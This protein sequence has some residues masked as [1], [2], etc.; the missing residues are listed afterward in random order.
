MRR[1][2][3]TLFVLSV[4][5]LVSAV[6]TARSEEEQCEKDNQAYLK[7]YSGKYLYTKPD[8]VSG[9][10]ITGE[11]VKPTTPLVG[12][13]ALP[14][15]N[16]HL[17]YRADIGVSPSTNQMFSFK[18]LPPAKYDLFILYKFEIYEG[19]SLC[20]YK[21]ALTPKDLKLIEYIVQKSEPYFGDGKTIHRVCGTTGKMKG[22][23][24][25]IVSM[26]N[27]KKSSLPFGGWTSSSPRRAIKLFHLEDVGPGW[28][29][30]ETREIMARFVTPGKEIPTSNYRSYLGKIRI[31]DVVKDLGKLDLS[32]PGEK[33]AP[34]PDAKDDID[35]GASIDVESEPEKTPE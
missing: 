34:L 23:A 16:P 10:G 12:V 15:D 19:L 28:Q 31:T 20:R 27:R 30:A 7:Y 24:T 14:P 35:T 29:V 1:Y 5:I 21:N 33:D 4:F 17:C 25:A 8:L 11:I 22:K 9:G 26:L 18:G 3:I 32:K 2:D 13:F 6:N